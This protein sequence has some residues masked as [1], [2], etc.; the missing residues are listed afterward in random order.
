MSRFSKKILSCKKYYQDLWKQKALM[1]KV[2]GEE[3]E[4]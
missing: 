1:G 2:L 3:N 4:K